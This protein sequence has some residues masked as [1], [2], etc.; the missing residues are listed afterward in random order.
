MAGASRLKEH[1]TGG[2]IPLLATDLFRLSYFPLSTGVHQVKILGSPT[3][4]I[5]YGEYVIRQGASVLPQ[6]ERDFLAAG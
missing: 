6:L 3:G 4:E 5:E 2:V 1:N